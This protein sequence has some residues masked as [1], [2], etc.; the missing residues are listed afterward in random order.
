MGRTMSKS[1]GP[2]MVDVAR[3][4]GVSQQTVSRVVNEAHNVSPEIRDRVNLAIGQL[5]YRRN[6]AAAALASRR[7]MNLGVVSFALSVH[8]PSLAL[9][10]ISEQ[11]RL[12]G[13]T[14]RL[15]TLGDLSHASFRSALNELTSSEVDGVVVLAPLYAAAEVL[16]GLETDVPIVTFAQGA[17]PSPTSVS[18][19]EVLGARVAVR[20]LLELGHKTVWHVQ[21]P[22][23]WMAS[24]ARQRGWAME[25]S[26]QGRVLPEPVVAPDWSARSGYEAALRLVDKPDVTAIFAG[27]DAFALGAI[28]AFDEH[29]FDIPADVSIV[30]FDDLAEAEFF[31]PS[32]T[33]V[34]LDFEEI[35]RLA[36]QRI[37]AMMRGEE[38]DVIPLIPPRLIVRDSTAI[39][40]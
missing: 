18:I 37:L 30:G 5:N 9:F 2:R 1:Q 13:Y 20:H 22:A 17:E 38:K 25:L 21:G 27:S 12:N 7:T 31:K 33:T 3:L 16:R 39:S 40:R 24:D 35:G 26:A 14:T 8:G 10:G 4:A 36:V 11:A 6:S 15:I 28:K 29:G 32:L 19:D 34:F 23:G